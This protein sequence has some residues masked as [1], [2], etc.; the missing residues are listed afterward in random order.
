M[1]ITPLLTSP[2]APVDPAAMQFPVV[3]SSR[4]RLARNLKEYPFS[5]WANLSQRREILSNCSEAI[6]TLPQMK[7][8]FFYQIEELDE[9][10]REILIE[11]HFIS[12]EL[13]HTE[14]GSAVAISSDKEISI[15]INEEDHLRLQVVRPGFNFR[16]LWKVLDGIDSALANGLDFAFDD[17]LGYLTACPTNLGT[18]LRASVMIHLPSLTLGGN[19]DQV[20]RAIGQMGLA[21]RGLYGEGS[22]A[23]GSI[24]Q[25]SNQ[26]TL[27]FTEEEI[28]T[29]LTRV[30]HSII[31]HEQNARA[32]L[33]ESGKTELC[34]RISR[35]EGLL[36]SSTSITSSEAMNLLSLLRLG[37]DLGA[38]PEQSRATLDALF[39]GCQPGH[40]Q[41]LSKTPAS[42]AKRDTLRATY[43]KKQ[44][45]KFPELDFKSIV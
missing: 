30:L 42:P 6:Q 31:G 5:S 43:L 18:G 29:N 45:E 24:F 12:K 16:R 38:L 41:I 40:I 33:L 44:F 35:A 9:I 37:V 34:N 15:M 8:S 26:R 39:I 17:Q 25:I 14:G 19:I 21:I 36:R 32:R 1:K 3:I 2:L 10:E 13:A 22:E 7:D 4:V 20:V 27:G 23:T 11:R 28:I